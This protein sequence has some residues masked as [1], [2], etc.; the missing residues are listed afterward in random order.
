[1]LIMEVIAKALP[2]DPRRASMKASF[3]SIVLAFAAFC[4]ST[5]AT[6]PVAAKTAVAKTPAIVAHPRENVAKNKP[7]TAARR[8]IRPPVREVTQCAPDDRKCE[9]DSK[10]RGSTYDL[11]F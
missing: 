6:T 3:S 2:S 1:M 4:G 7:Q 8:T 11:G 5:P 9:V 10:L